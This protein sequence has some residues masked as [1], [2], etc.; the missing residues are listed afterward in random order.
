MPTN[1]TLGY[2]ITVSRFNGTSYVPFAE[3][4]DVTPPNV[5]RDSIGVSHHGSP[6]GY[7][8]FIPG[9]RD[10]GEISLTLNWIPSATE[11]LLVAF[12]SGTV[13]S[14][15]ITLPNSVTCTFSGFVMSHSP[16][17]PRDDKMTL[18]VT[19]KVSGAPVWA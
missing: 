13:D 11:T 17:T 4:V 18:A 3:I 15:R 7:K 8:E 6:G 16:A 14:F 12:N 10:G 1:V 2:G 9:L 5:S 19:L